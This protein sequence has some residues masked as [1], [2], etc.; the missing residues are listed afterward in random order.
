MEPPAGGQ[1]FVAD[2]MLGK[3]AKWLRVLGFDAE[4]RR[5]RSL[6]EVDDCSA[7]RVLVLTRNHRYRDHPGVLFVG[8]DDALEQLRQVVH[9]GAIDTGAVRFLSRCLRCNVTLVGT[10]RE[11]ARGRVPDYVF[12]HAAGF[13]RCPRCQ[14]FYWAGS[15]PG[16]MAERLE[17]LVG[18]RPESL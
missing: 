7:R 13:S 8:D 5:I 10:E 17:A 6:A 11:A 3:L 9:A 16:R 2:S 12:E 1:R 15:H 4:Y 14:R 18:W